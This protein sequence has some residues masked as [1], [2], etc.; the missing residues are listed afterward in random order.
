[1]ESKLW[2]LS[3]DSY[4]RALTA[5]T[6]HLQAHF[7]AKSRKFDGKILCSRSIQA[8]AKTGPVLTNDAGALNSGLMDLFSVIRQFGIKITTLHGP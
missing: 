4:T 1:M 3:R 2:T 6:A 5:S 7:N 8:V